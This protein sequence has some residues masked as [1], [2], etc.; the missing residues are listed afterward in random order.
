MVNYSSVNYLPGPG[1]SLFDGGERSDVPVSPQ[2]FM[3][4]LEWGDNWLALGLICV[5]ARDELR[6]AG[7]RQDE[8]G[9]VRWMRRKG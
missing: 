4:C 2:S 5:Y 1:V 6:G 9:D 3:A 7:G 8:A